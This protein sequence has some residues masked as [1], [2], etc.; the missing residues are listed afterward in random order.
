MKT[1]IN[2]MYSPR[3]AHASSKGWLEKMTVEK[4]DQFYRWWLRQETG[5]DAAPEN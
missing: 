5:Q 2:S 1:S 4:F 3:H